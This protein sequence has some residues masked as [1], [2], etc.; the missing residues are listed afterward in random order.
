MKDFSLALSYG[1]E[2]IE[3]WRTDSFGAG[4][5]TK[6]EI[7]DTLEDWVKDRESA[8]GRKPEDDEGY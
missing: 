8:W 5:P 6:K 2:I 7:Q 4:L 1:D 3:Q